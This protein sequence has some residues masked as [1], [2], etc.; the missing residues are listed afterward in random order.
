M[1]RL[2]ILSLPPLPARLEALLPPARSL[3][4]ALPRLDTPLPPAERSL[5]PAPPRLEL[6]RLPPWRLV[7]CR[8]LACRLAKESPRAVPPYLLAVA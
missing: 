1:S 7:C 8:A 2:P 3:A 6:L 4:P 5:T